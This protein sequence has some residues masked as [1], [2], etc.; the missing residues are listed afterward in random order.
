MGRKDDLY[1]ILL[2][3]INSFKFAQPLIICRGEAPW[4][5]QQYNAVK[6]DTI[7]D[8]MHKLSEEA[9][10]KALKDT[11]TEEVKNHTV[12]TTWKSA[13]G[14]F[15]S[16]YDTAA[17]VLGAEKMK[18][19]NEAGVK[20]VECEIDTYVTI[21]IVKAL[22]K[23]MK[24][25]EIATRKDSAKKDIAKPGKPQTFAKVFSATPI[26]KADYDFYKTEAVA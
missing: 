1:S 19:L 9:L 17:G 26:Y 18:T 13:Q 4:G 8:T 10:I 14:K 7:S 21:Q 5:E 16:C 25:C 12:T 22:A 20:K 15:N 3:Y 6:G 2:A 24:E 23:R 11:V